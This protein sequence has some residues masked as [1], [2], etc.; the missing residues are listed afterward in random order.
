M[1]AIHDTA[2]LYRLA[3][4]SSEETVLKTVNTEHFHIVSYMELNSYW[5]DEPHGGPYLYTVTIC[6]FFDMHA[7]V[8]FRA[9]S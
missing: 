6:Q 2:W 8:V 9:S 5:L 1:S 7:E 3:L 4:K